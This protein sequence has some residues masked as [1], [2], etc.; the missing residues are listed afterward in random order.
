MQKI[1]VVKPLEA[2]FQ[3]WGLW[4]PLELYLEVVWFALW[5]YLPVSFCDEVNDWQ[6]QLIQGVA[7]V[8]FAHSL[9]YLVRKKKATGCLFK[10]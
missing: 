1:A 8:L 2:D 10:I 4:V 9:E 6:F 5:L 3:V 7:S